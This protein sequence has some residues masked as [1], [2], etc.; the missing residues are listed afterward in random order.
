MV[1]SCKAAVAGI[2][3]AGAALCFAALAACGGGSSAF[4][5]AEFRSNYALGNV[6]VLS[7]Y[8]AGYTGAG[9]T[10]AII[11]TGFDLNHFDLNA[12]ISASSIDSVVNSFVTV[13]DVDGHGTAV[14]GVI[15]AEKNGFGM[16]GIAY[17][18]TLL[19]IRA[20]ALGSCFPVL[21]CGFIDPDLADA[22]DYAVAQGA[23]VINMSLGGAAPRDEVLTTAMKNATDAGVIIVIASGNESTANPSY[24]ALYAQ[25]ATYGGLIIAVG[26][27][28]QNDNIADFSNL[29]G[30]AEDFFLVAPGVNVRTTSNSGG[31][32]TFSGTSFSSP[33]VAGAVAL[34]K[35]RFPLL[36]P[37]EVVDLLLLTAEDLGP[38][39]ADSTY[40]QGLLDVSAAMA[41]LGWITV[42]LPGGNDP[43]LIDTR[44]A[45]GPAFGDALT[46]EAALVG[47]LGLD[48]W[49]RAFPLDLRGGVVAAEL[50]PGARLGAFLRGDGAT[51][52][53]AAAG[54]TTLALRLS[55]D[56]ARTTAGAGHAVGG[57][58]GGIR[59]S[60][61]LLGL[62]L[63]R[64]TERA[65]IGLYFGAPATAGPAAVVPG[66][67]GVPQLSLLG[68]GDG[69]SASRGLG[70]LTLT[71][72]VHR[73]SAPAEVG[74]GGGTLAQ[75]WL[76]GA[77]P[78]ADGRF[79]LGLG[80]LDERSALLRT[81][82][83][84]VFGE[85]RGSRSRFLTLAAAR[86]AG[87]GM[88]VFGAFTQA[89]AKPAVR[90][91]IFSEFGTVRA[92]SFAAGLRGSDVWADGDRLTFT[93]GQP[94]RVERADAKLAVPVARDGGGG[95]RTE[96]RPVR[97]VPSGR[98][99]N[100]ELS[101]SRMLGAS[102]LVTAFA[103]VTAE[104]GHVKGARTAAFAG[105]RFSKSF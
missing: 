65:E 35:E 41:P 74:G 44:Y 83:S 97:V 15:G 29:A 51:T 91:G 20:D 18:A 58:G 30:T 42:P 78:G 53:E 80:V 46:T 38:G 56:R 54:D 25:D 10:V 55:T 69:V 49:N 64:Q 85:L 8:E 67:A 43:G 103:G 102:A 105:A 100:L 63:S 95:F 72:S 88:E 19:A 22:V 28:D 23:G 24:P 70:A 89:W 36:D 81:T 84:G 75:A 68:P 98:E 3:R 94:L 48:G 99:R 26:A 96:T 73:A 16:H 45:L 7:T 13:D 101:Y 39:G 2:R 87:R 31:F 61:R 21:N 79:A 33:L 40:G 1:F 92:S 32:G 86:P 90:G 37:D 34:L 71:G 4:N 77:L 104:P 93:L 17:E 76:T 62:A 52:V 6:S 14:A 12:N 9:Q 59:E 82:A 5:T 27:V 57:E 66:A 11:D 47:V 60:A 50:A